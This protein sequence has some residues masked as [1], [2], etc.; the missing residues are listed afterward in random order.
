MAGPQ[1]L[2]ARLVPVQVQV[3]QRQAVQ[4][5]RQRSSS[6]PA[7]SKRAREMLA[8]ARARVEVVQALVAERLEPALAELVARGLRCFPEHSKSTR[9]MWAQAKRLQAQRIRA[10]RQ[11]E[12]VQVEAARAPGL[13]PVQRVQA[14]VAVQGQ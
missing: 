3:A 1:V 12:Q 11:A 5:A 4:A 14:A 6:F 7:H 8:R 10:A 13:R 2:A 9:M